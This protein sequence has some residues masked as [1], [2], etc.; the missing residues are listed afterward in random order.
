VLIQDEKKNH[1]AWTKCGFEFE[2]KNMHARESVDLDCEEKSW[3]MD[4]VRIWTQ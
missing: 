3:S 1:G 2:N 4:E